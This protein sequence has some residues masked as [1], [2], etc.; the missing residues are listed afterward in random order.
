MASSA[1]SIRPQTGPL[2]PPDDVLPTKELLDLP[3]ELIFQIAT[4]YLND[5]DIW[6]LEQVC[7]LPLLSRYLIGKIAIPEER[8]HL[9]H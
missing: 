9:R 7:K 3:N 6:S 1:S 4:N 8:E 5:K 2:T